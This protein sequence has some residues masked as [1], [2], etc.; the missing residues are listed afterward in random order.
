MKNK[1]QEQRIV[2]NSVVLSTRLDGLSK[3][4]IEKE[5]RLEIPCRG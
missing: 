3:Y 1:G 4:P 2:E 5:I